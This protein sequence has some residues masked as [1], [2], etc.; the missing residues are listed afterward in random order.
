MRV[1]DPALPVGDAAKGVA[2]DD[3]GQYR[4]RTRLPMPA[5]AGSATR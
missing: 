1:G 5:T 2:S 4:A 3:A